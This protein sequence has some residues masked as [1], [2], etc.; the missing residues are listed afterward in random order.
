MSQALSLV[1]G[2]NSGVSSPMRTAHV[3][4]ILAAGLA[5]H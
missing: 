4:L 5:A 1:R 2:E 3:S